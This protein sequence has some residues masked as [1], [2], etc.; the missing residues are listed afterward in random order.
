MI[1]DFILNGKDVSVNVPSYKRLIHILREE[2]KLTATHGDCNRG[3][4]GRCVILL[5]DELAHACLLPAFKVKG[6]RVMTF[7]GFR[8]TAGYEDI[9]QGFKNS[10]CFPCEYCTSTRYLAAHTLL[11]TTFRPGEKEIV[12]YMSFIKCSCI[13]FTSLFTG[14]KEAGRIR[15]ERVGEK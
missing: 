13:D 1:I 12:S 10:G 9:R 4:C 11:E 8:K 6:N 3:E 7:E 5:N 15:E 14:L 2:Q